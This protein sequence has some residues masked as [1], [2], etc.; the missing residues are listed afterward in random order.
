MLF[1]WSN[2]NYAESRKGA[3]A[4]MDTWLLR[5][6]RNGSI[7]QGNAHTRDQFLKASVISSKET[8]ICRMR[9][10]RES[11]PAAFAKPDALL[12]I[13]AVMALRPRYA[14]RGGS[15]GPASKPQ[16]QP[17]LGR[18]DASRRRGSEG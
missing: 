14:S 8:C 6:T 9:A 18:A 13:G 3:A 16:R 4:A 2:R 11:R 5:S 1:S 12:A 7:T 10:G 15:C 17:R